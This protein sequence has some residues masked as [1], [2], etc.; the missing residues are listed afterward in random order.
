LR[1]FLFIMIYTV[2]ILY[3]KSCHKFYTGQ[4]QD[5]DNRVIEHNA[6]ETKSIKS[7]ISW[8]VIWKTVCESRGE[9]M[10]LERRIK[11]HGASRFL[12]DIGITPEFCGYRVALRRQDR[13]FE[14]G[15]LERTQGNF[16]TTF[17]F[18]C[19]KFYLTSSSLMT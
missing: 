4:S 1:L 17:A 8:Q 6:G 18:L 14:S 11:S 13:Q 19:S 12:S 7:C 3:S 2:Y 16:F 5:V 10:K 15:R 9:A